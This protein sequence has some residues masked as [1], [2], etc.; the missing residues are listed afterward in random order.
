LKSVLN[1]AL[2]LLFHSARLA[3]FLRLKQYQTLLMKRI[4]TLI[5]ILFAALTAANTQPVSS[6]IDDPNGP[7]IKFETET[8]SFDSA[9]QGTVVVK[10]Y[11]F[12]NTGKSPLIISGATG[13]CSC[14]IPDYPKQPIAPGKS[15][16]IRVEFKSEGKMG[17]QDKT[18]TITS[19]A[20][21]GVVVLHLKGKIVAAP[22]VKK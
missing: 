22:P 15:G 20:N 13:S 6:E 2:F 1:R 7:V 11:K 19:N 12:T 17:Y 14:T 4:A 5:A 21:N 18:A 9:T 8:I 3:Q 10:E 16:V